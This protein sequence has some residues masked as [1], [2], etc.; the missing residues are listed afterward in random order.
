MAQELSASARRVQAALA[1][2]GFAMQVVEFA[3]TTRTAADAAAAIGCTVAQIAK[4]IVFRSGSRAVVVIT[5]GA[6][7]VDAK[8][9]AAALGVAVKRADADFVREATGF[10][11]GGVAP[12]G[13]L[14]PPLLLFDRDLLDLHPIWAAAGSPS[15]VFRTE[16]ATLAR[17]TG[18][19]VADVKQDPG[20]A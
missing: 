8:K 7:R 18:A 9:V 12:L 11:I 10:A 14:A 17:I 5:S 15:H 4:S 3:T 6:N 13:H 1:A 20:A 19:P 16:A 2:R